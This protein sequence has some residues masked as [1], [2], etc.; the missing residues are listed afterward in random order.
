MREAGRT[1]EISASRRERARRDLPP[2]AGL[3]G[4]A[5][6]VHEPPGR[7]DPGADARAAQPPVGLRRARHLPHAAA[8]VRAR[9]ARRRSRRSATCRWSGR[10]RSGQ[11]TADVKELRLLAEDAPG[12][13]QAAPPVP[14]D[15]RRPQEAVEPDNRARR[16]R[17]ARGRQDAHARSS[18]AGFTG[19][20][21]IWNYFFWQALSTNPL[22]DIGPRAAA[23][24]R[25]E[26]VCGSYQVKPSAD[27]HRPVQPVHGAD[28]AGRHD[29][30]P[31]PAG[32]RV[33]VR[34]RAR[35]A[36][37]PRRPPSARRPH[38]QVGACTD[39]NTALDYLL[40]Q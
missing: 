17:P 18:R 39:A 26:P 30:G 13:R 24:H 25:R 5:R 37:A 21:A 28:A 14:P 1:A 36:A 11:T 10:A 32:S 20:E 2:P 23:E 6:A 40:G 8:P 16:D 12:L 7:P 33:G 19:M 38:G 22:D 3:P 29:R 4:R 31:D 9:R 15:D 35:G 27:A 34:R